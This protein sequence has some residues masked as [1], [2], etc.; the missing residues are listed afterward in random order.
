M[1]PLKG[2]EHR[3]GP[4]STSQTEMLSFTWTSSRP[5]STSGLRVG[6]SGASCVAG[7]DLLLSAVRVMLVSPGALLTLPSVT[8]T[9][10]VLEA[11]LP[12]GRT[13]MKQPPAAG[14][15]K[16]VGTTFG[17]CCCIGGTVEG[18]LVGWWKSTTLLLDLFH[19]SS[20]ISKR[21][22][23]VSGTVS[24]GWPLMVTSLDAMTACQKHTTFTRSHVLWARP[25]KLSN[26]SNEKHNAP[27]HEKVDRW[28]G[29]RRKSSSPKSQLE[30]KNNPCC[31]SLNSSEWHYLGYNWVR[32]DPWV[33]EEACFSISRGFLIPASRRPLVATWLTPQPIPMLHRRKSITTHAPFCTPTDWY[34]L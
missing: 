8:A 22:A 21:I 9:A 10:S 27:S 28:N 16:H 23:I 12:E 31:W 29:K 26:L 18:W 30:T 19:M 6:G 5:G 17:W 24:A 15:G 14:C 32:S 7:L 3:T 33:G 34:W 1:V 25:V 20:A 11:A 2:E 4:S 13:G